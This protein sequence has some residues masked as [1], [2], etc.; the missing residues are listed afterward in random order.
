MDYGFWLSFRH[1]G[2]LWLRAIRRR[3][4]RLSPIFLWH[5]W[6]F[7]ELVVDPYHS[8]IPL[9]WQRSGKNQIESTRL[10]L[11]PNCAMVF[12]PLLL[13]YRKHLVLFNRAS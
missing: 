7:D 10:R 2:L 11:K 8:R 5:R 12:F 6:L 9:V 3:L 4:C 1:S 13:N